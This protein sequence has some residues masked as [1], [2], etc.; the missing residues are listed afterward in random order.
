[1]SCIKAAMKMLLQKVLQNL[2]CFIVSFY[3]SVSGVGWSVFVSTFSAGAPVFL[4][5]RIFLPE[6]PKS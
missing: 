2:L 4:Y 1:M 5:S 6:S 3:G